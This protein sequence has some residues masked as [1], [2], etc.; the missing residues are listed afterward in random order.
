VVPHRTLTV[1]CTGGAPVHRC[2]SGGP[3]RTAGPDAAVVVVDLRSLLDP[4]GAV[5]IADLAART[6]S[7]SV[8][9]WIR[10]GR[11]VRLLPHV[12]VLP[13]VGGRWRTRAAAAVL[14]TGGL[15]SHTSALALWD[16]VEPGG[17]V[18]V[19]I[20]AGRR[21]PEPVDWLTVHR[22]GHLPSRR[23]AGLPVTPPARSAADAWGIAHATGGSPAAVDAAR[24]AVITAV[25][26]G[27]ATARELRAE[28]ARRPQ[29]PGRAA[30]FE[31]LSLVAAGA[32]SELEIWG[33]LHVVDVPGLPPCRRQLRVSLPRGHAVLDVAWPEA[34]L[35]VELDGAA[36]HGSP[37]QRER[38]LRR[39]AALAAQGWLV[40]R[41]S[42]RRLTR[43]PDV[44]RA[45]IAAVYRSRLA[46]RR[47]SRVH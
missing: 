14:S 6:G 9:R 21:A 33:L 42:Y 2:G 41:F 7:T 22:T 36:F 15:L 11:L 17:R 39:D 16:L 30:L 13:E 18:H 43:E 44:C 27:L 40:L 47:P 10:E 29:L 31:L 8:T 32:H 20:P 19:S 46:A 3:L 4:D 28:L 37:E 26:T 24:G 34:R 1:S 35:A 25:R 23:R 45:E 5:R 38:D 12:V